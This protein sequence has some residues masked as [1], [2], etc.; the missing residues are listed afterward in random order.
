MNFEA[1]FGLVIDL[2]TVYSQPLLGVMLCVFVG[3]IW[4]RD[5]VLKEIK[6]GHGDIESTLFWK[7]WPGYVKFFCPVLILATFIQS[8]IG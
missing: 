8:I 3:W 7:I 1:L 5:N 6:K 2:T 4:H